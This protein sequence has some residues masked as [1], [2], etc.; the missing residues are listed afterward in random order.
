MRRPGPRAHS[1]ATAL[2][3]LSAALAMAEAQNR[4]LE[5]LLIDAKKA[6]DKQQR[7]FHHRIKNSLQ[8]IQS[9]LALSRRERLPERNSNLV[10]AEARVLVISG[11]YRLAL[12]EGNDHHLCVKALIDQ[13]VM[14]ALQLLPTPEQHIRGSTAVT[15]VLALDQ[16]IPIGLGIVEAAISG[17]A[18]APRGRLTLTC[19]RDDTNC[20]HILLAL[21]GAEQPFPGPN[22]IIRGLQ[23]QVGATAPPLAEGIIL[24]WRIAPSETLASISGDLD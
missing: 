6:Y 21:A 18:I 1:Q 7:A 12:G 15:E 19:T 3:K 24:D 16:A 22:R 2:A 10:E 23:A 5:L 14:S 11:A 4:T 13:I 17:L 8:I 9:Y 20:L